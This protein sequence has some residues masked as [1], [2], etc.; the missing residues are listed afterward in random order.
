[1]HSGKGALASFGV[2]LRR[3]RHQKMS[4]LLVPLAGEAVAN[5]DASLFGMLLDLEGQSLRM[6]GDFMITGDNGAQDAMLDCALGAG[7]DLGVRVHGRMLG[8]GGGGNVLVFVD[9]SDPAKRKQWEASAVKAYDAWAEAKYP[10]KGI[11][12]TVIVPAISAGARLL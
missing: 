1:M 11:K 6:S 12:A 4:S 7:R 3:M 9:G 2:V 8:G 10:G 5:G